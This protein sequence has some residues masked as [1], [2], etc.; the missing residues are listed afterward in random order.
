MKFN[1]SQPL[2][3]LSGEPVLSAKLEP[4]TIGQ[5]LGNNLI[6]QSS[7]DPLKLMEWCAKMYKGEDVDLDTADQATLKDLIKQHQ[8]MVVLVKAAALDIMEKTN[9]AKKS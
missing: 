3:Q 2:N 8:S 4:M 1:F 5:V 6:N 9:S 7:G